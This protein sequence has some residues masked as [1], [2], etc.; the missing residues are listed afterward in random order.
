MRTFHRAV[1]VLAVLFPAVMVASPATALKRCPPLLVADDNVCRCAVANYG[2]T[3][4]TGVTITIFNGVGT[5]LNQCTP[6]IA[7]KGNVGCNVTA[8]SNAISCACAVKGEG[9]A[10]R[11][12][13]SVLDASNNILA[14]VEC[15]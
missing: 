7:A 14:A 12:S 13:L 2:I 9:S 11:V 15:R 4:D 1:V 10:A 3:S 8:S 6:T 5:E